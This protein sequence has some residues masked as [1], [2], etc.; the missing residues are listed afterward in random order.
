[1]LRV[2]TFTWGHPGRAGGSVGGAAGWL[3]D[4]TPVWF[5]G[6]GSSRTVLPAHAAQLA[7]WLPTPAGKPLDDACVLIDFFARYPVREVDALPAGERAPA[8]PLSGRYRVAFENGQVVVLEARGELSLS[9]DPG[10]IRIRGRLGLA[11]YLARVVDREGDPG[12]TEAARALAVVA[13]TWL[14]QN[15]PFEGGCFQVEDSTRAQRVSPRPSTRAAAQAALFTDGLV[16]RGETVRYRLEG[17]EPGAL[18]WKSA[19]QQARDGRRY[20]QILSAAFPRAS[21]AA[22][23]GEQECRQL[24]EVQAWLAGRAPRWQRALSAQPGFEAPTETL[25]VCALGHGNPYVDR[26]RSRIYLRGLAG[27]EDRLT[28]AHEYVHLAFPFHPCG[29]DEGCVE[30]LAR[31]LTEE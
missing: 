21:L 6:I 19:V 1:M 28:L 20:D 18:A 11:D 14:L 31:T 8:G 29:L 30:R 7:A 5:A 12:A 27:R 3:V 16:L 25:T 13:R 24:P 2:K 22:V 4:G 17:N 15:A 9:R 10:R 26:S 23:T